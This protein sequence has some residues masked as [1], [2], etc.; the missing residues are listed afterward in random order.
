MNDDLRIRH[1]TDADWDVIVA[2]E[3]R[4]Y[5]GLGLSEGRAALRSRAD[6]SPGTC[7]VLD[8]GS[9]PAGYLLA[10][11]Y[12]A[13]R[14]PE[15]ER[16]EDTAAPPPSPGNLHLHD[17]VVTERLRGR[18]LAQHLLNHLTLTAR[19]RGDER[20]S[21]VAVGRSE[22]FWSARGFTAHPGVRPGGYGAHAVYMSKATKRA[23]LLVPCP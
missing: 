22:P 1:I 15:L 9:R 13:G 5:A 14:Y 16:T 3:S 12:Q 7:F 20:I 4:A 17:I 6:A 10:L 11:P 19:T 8:F 23:D 18:G 21:L 2:M